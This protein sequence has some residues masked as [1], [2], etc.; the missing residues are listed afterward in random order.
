MF[1]LCIT[2]IIYSKAALRQHTAG[3]LELRSTSLAFAAPDA[4]VRY[5]CDRYLW[6]AVVGC[7]DHINRLT[8]PISQF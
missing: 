3:S 1:G 6:I 4:I 2:H 7:D 8:V 5:C